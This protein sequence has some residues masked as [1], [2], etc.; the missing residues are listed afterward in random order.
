MASFDQQDTFHKVQAII[1]DKLKIADISHITA[2]S[3]LQDLGADS[4]DMADIILKMEEQFG[5]EIND[6]DAERLC[7]VGD[8]VTY[9][10]KLRIK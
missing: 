2:E 9:V 4:L 1:A 5:I 8:V 6:E 7:N 10:N 3:T